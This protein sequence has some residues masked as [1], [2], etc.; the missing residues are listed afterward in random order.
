MRGGAR[1][2]ALVPGLR[3]APPHTRGSAGPAWGA[4]TRRRQS[5]LAA[6]P[7]LPHLSPDPPT[8]PPQSRPPRGKPPSGLGPGVQLTRERNSRLPLPPRVVV[9]GP[10]PPA[11]GLTEG[12]Q[13]AFNRTP[14]RTPTPGHSARPRKADRA[15]ASAPH[16]S[17]WPLRRDHP[18]G[19]RTRTPRAKLR[20]RE[21]PP[22]EEDRPASVGSIVPR[23]ARPCWGGSP[24]SP[25]I[26]PRVRVK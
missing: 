25:R 5:S 26:P 6:E 15:E 18:C 9:R 23:C 12:R 3:G 8:V 19:R 7:E 14:G 11:G 4:R 1:E 2:R 10:A 13:T 22:A 21:R 24:E 17:T 16:T 20:G